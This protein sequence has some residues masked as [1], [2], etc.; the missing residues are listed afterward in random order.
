MYSM[1]KG[2]S[3]VFEVNGAIK[4]L[5]AAAPRANLRFEHIAGVENVSDALSRG[6]HG[7]R[8]VGQPSGANMPI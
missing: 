7:M 3:G 4:L 8:E 2:Y 5:Q 1:R 6:M